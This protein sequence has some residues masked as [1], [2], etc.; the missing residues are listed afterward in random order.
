MDEKYNLDKF[1]IPATHE[2]KD[3]DHFMSTDSEAAFKKSLIFMPADWSYRTKQVRYNTNSLGYRTKELAD[4]DQNNFFIAYGCSFTFG[5]GLA[6]DELWTTTVSNELGIECLNLGMGGAGMDFIYLNTLTY[7][8][9]THVRPKFVIIQCHEVSRLLMRS[10]DHYAMLG[11]NFAVSSNA[12]NM[13]NQ[14]I[15]DNSY[16]YTAYLAWHST[17]TFWK[18]AG[19]PVHCWT[20]NKEWPALIPGVEFNLSWPTDEEKITKN[21]AR[22]L[23][24]F[25]ASY[26]IRTG[27][28][29]VEKIRN[30]P[31]F[32]IGPVD[33]PN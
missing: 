8:K 1:A 16:L 21:R 24:H 3:N 14:S 27:K 9:N 10:L 19:V 4:I 26:Q 33:N 13:Y 30:D 32:G 6:E 7:L 5:I 23:Q 28:L 15:K 12:N 17:M 18:T 29:V 11:P 20:Q 22:D 31:K 25:P 2:W